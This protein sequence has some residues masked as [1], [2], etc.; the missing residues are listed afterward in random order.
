MAQYT[1]ELDRESLF[2]VADPI[3]N[4]NYTALNNEDPP[5]T[6]IGA[7]TNVMIP[8]SKDDMTKKKSNS[9][10]PTTPNATQSATDVSDDTPLTN[11]QIPLVLL[12]VCEEYGLL[13]SKQMESSMI[14][15]G[16]S[17][18]ITR[19]ALR[20]F[21]KGYLV[22]ITSHVLNSVQENMNDMRTEV[23]KLQVQTAAMGAKADKI[24]KSS[25]GLEDKIEAA[26]KTVETRFQSTLE[27][28]ET[29]V[30]EKIRT[31]SDVVEST[32][33]DKVIRDTT[34]ETATLKPT[35]R[36]E[37]TK[38]RDVKK[39]TIVIPEEVKPVKEI[40]S[41]ASTSVASTTD[42][43]SIRAA[44]ML[45]A[46]F[47]KAFVQSIPDAI[48]IEI[49]PPDLVTELKSTVMTPRIKGAVK[50]AILA[51]ISKRNNAS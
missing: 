23:R 4:I 24:V 10:G 44:L 45:R 9:G 15:A 39:V 6:S 11:R 22:C 30:R 18:V 1:S 25:T 26:S 49:I 27:N 43:V 17:N 20:W 40:G 35:I 48:M 50:S 37:D 28:V 3:D 46:G 19:S 29:F 38:Q 36:E 31:L 32:I 41:S 42:P 14:R 47:T 13:M 16:S 12:E 7:P 51:N 5:E 21:V 8:L 34:K 33:E 2:D